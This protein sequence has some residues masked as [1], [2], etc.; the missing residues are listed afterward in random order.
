VIIL[1][2]KTDQP[3]AELWLYEDG[4][5]LQ[6]QEWSAHLKLAETINSEIDKILNLVNKLLDE[7]SNLNGASKPQRLD[8]IVA[9]KGPGSFTGLRI[10]LTVANALAYANQIP[11]VARTGK[12]WLQTGI[13]DILLGKD[14]KVAM[15]FYDRPAATT[16]PKN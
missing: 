3:T 7:S 13:D 8:G 12:N 4:K 10:G 6:Y 2:L 11:I 1:G 15:P 14:D 9:F 16:P 5:K